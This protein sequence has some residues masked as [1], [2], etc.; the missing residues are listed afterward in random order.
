MQTIID[1]TSVSSSQLPGDEDAF[2]FGRIVCQRLSIKPE[3]FVGNLFSFISHICDIL[4]GTNLL[5]KTFPTSVKR[6]K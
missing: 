2:V 4:M 5:I 6:E 1:L 3:N